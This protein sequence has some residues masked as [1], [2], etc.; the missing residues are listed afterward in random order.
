ML[1]AIGGPR[2][3]HLL[4]GLLHMHVAVDPLRELT[5]GTVDRHPLGLDRDAHSG[6]Y[7]DWLSSDTGHR[8]RSVLP[9]P[10]HDFAADPLKAGIVAGHQTLGGGDD[11]GAHP[12][13]DTWDVPVVDIRALAGARD[14]LQAGDHRF[15][16]DGVLERHRELVARP[17]LPRRM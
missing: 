3:Q 13:L 9:D 16:V 7:S 1:A 17:S 10:G 2:D 15:T 6:R 5:P 12:A 11:R 8:S 14:S 4:V